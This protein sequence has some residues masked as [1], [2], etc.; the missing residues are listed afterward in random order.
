MLEEIQEKIKPEQ[1]LQLS[2]NIFKGAKY[3]F[4]DAQVF[5][6]LKSRVYISIKYSK[7]LHAYKLLKELEKNLSQQDDSVK[8]KY[9]EI[10]IWLNYACFGELTQR[11]ILDFFSKKN[12]TIIL[13]DEDYNDLIQKIKFRLSQEPI[14]TRDKWR[15]KIF[16]ALHENENV[17]IQG[18]EGAISAWIKK[19]DNAV[20]TDIAESIKRANFESESSISAH[21]SQD[22]KSLLKRFLGFYEFIKISSY[23]PAGFEESVIVEAGGKTY[24]F[25]EGKQT[26]I[27]S[28]PK[29]TRH[30]GGRL[31]PTDRIYSDNHEDSIASA[32]T[33]RSRMTK[34]DETELKNIYDYQKVL[35]ARDNLLIESKGDVEL[36][37]DA[38]IERVLASLLLLSQLRKL[39]DI[40]SNSQF[41]KMVSDDLKKSSQDDKVQGLRINPKA[42]QFIARF[43]K[44]VLEDKLKLSHEDAVV[45]GSKLSQ[46]L[47]IEGEKYSS[48][49]KEGKWNL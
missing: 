37:L 26:E 4:G 7:S 33:L 42:P 39:D 15:E 32:G 19:Y 3:D 17:L 48:I 9:K 27:L 23:D 2:R 13:R 49:I 12:F 25:D 29:S 20:G 11:E 47:S 28:A 10:I 6:D 43:L 34:S 14:E 31:L 18:K 5:E 36:L 41:S 21:L 44:I 40:L 46:I 22:E 24:L 45:F 1:E 35:Q 38:P 16:K 8:A 30:S